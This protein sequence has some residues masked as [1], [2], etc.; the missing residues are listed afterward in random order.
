MDMGNLTKQCLCGVTVYTATRIAVCIKVIVLFGLAVFYFS[1]GFS[2]VSVIPLV[3]IVLCGCMLVGMEKKRPELCRIYLIK[4]AIFDEFEF[5]TLVFGL[6]QGS[7]FIGF[8]FAFK[9][10]SFYLYVYFFIPYWTW[11]LLLHEIN[12]KDAVT[13][14]QREPQKP[15]NVPDN[16]VVPSC[17]PPE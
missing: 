9:L 1:R 14:F 13:V 15:D 17:P 5:G 4:T 6:T 16:I 7:S 11:K 2:F 10:L 8:V 3:D 12:T